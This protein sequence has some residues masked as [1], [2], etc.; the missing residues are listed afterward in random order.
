[1]NK[2]ALLSVFAIISVAL[3]MPLAECAYVEPIEIDIPKKTLA[4]ELL[5]TAEET[6]PIVEKIAPTGDETLSIVEEI[7]PSAEETSPIAVETWPST[8]ETVETEEKPVCICT[9]EY[10]PICGSDNHTYSN[11]CEF[12]CVAESKWGKTL[13]LFLMHYGRC[14]NMNN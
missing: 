8:E 14:M 1:M 13:N 5:S 12:I 9:M 6:S 7:K 10:N 2:I 4:E 11:N 3:L